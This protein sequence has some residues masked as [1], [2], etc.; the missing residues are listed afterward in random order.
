MSALA[1]KLPPKFK[2][3][4][5]LWL[6]VAISLFAAFAVIARAYVDP[7]GYLSPDSFAY[8][9]QA[10][11]FIEGRGFESDL[12]RLLEPRFLATWP[13]GYPALIAAVGWVLRLD[14]WWASKVLNGVLLI[15]I[16][17]ILRPIFG[18][19]VWIPT[20][21]LLS[22]GMIG[23]FSYTWS[24]GPFLVGQLLFVYALVRFAKKGGIV[25]V[26]LLTFAAVSLFLLRYIGAFALGV[27]AFDAL[28]M[29]LRRDYRRSVMLVAI[30][31]VAGAI[32]LG[33]LYNNQH[34][35]GHYVGYSRVA[36]DE[37]RWELTVNLLEAQ[38]TEL[39]FV[40]DSRPREIGSTPFILILAISFALIGMTL[41]GLTDRTVNR[42]P[43][44]LVK[45][46]YLKTGVYY[47]LLVGAAYWVAIVM[48]RFTSDFDLFSPR[49][50]VT[51]R[52]LA[53]STLF[54]FF[55]VIGM[56]LTFRREWL[57][58]VI[59]LL[60]LL[61][62]SSVAFNVVHTPIEEFR[63]ADGET[64]VDMRGAALDTYLD[65]PVGSLM[66]CGN[67]HL[68][69]TRPDLKLVTQRSCRVNGLGRM[70]ERYGTRYDGPAYLVVNGELKPIVETIPRIPTP[71]SP[72]DDAIVESLTPIFEWEPFRHGGDGD[73]QVG[74][75]LRVR[76]DDEGGRIVYD[77][78]FVADTSATNHR[79][80]VGIY[81]KIDK[82]TDM[83]RY[84][85]PL[86]PSGH[87]HWHLRVQD[88]TG[89]WSAWSANAE[90][91]FQDFV[92]SEAAK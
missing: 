70:V 64:F 21:V 3:S 79:Y 31:A 53:P 18:R 58:G 47:F 15:S 26:L 63:E 66:I 17:F 45:P 22:G 87:Y 32:M 77:T 20:L 61:A 33:Y 51:S 75:Q 13:F 69:Y 6:A 28:I 19:D 12:T 9:R 24:E 54:L 88:S 39:N 37:T 30:A 35:N 82:V 2:A 62:V 11:F 41:V 90:D 34:L 46:E 59:Y 50:V 14:P 52:L 85:M 73:T 23:I 57:P 44:S 60:V 84:S 25:S 38:T 92:V 4:W 49:I 68:R 91:I 10:A 40:F 48:M 27:L 8:L 29:L 76:A 36:P 56:V 42:G 55:G 71:I 67:E 65:V 5:G 7:V 86:K 89:V 72:A 83:Q 78:G 1:A 80:E 81:D 74:Y 43:P 16:P